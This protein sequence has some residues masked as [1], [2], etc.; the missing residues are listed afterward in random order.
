MGLSDRNNTAYKHQSIQYSTTTTFNGNMAKG[1]QTRTSRDST[2][3]QMNC[4][5][6]F[7]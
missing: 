6:S 4:E 7:K 2:K 1:E 5:I 3:L